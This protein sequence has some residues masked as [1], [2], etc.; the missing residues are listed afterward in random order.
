[1]NSRNLRAIYLII[2]IA[3]SVPSVYGKAK[4]SND[5]PATK[6]IN[7]KEKFT[8]LKVEGNIE[9]NYTQNS[10]APKAIVKAPVDLMD[11]I[12]Y[13][14]TPQGMLIFKMSKNTKNYDKIVIDL[15]GGLLNNYDVTATAQINILTPVMGK[16][17]FNFAASSS[18]MV[19]AQKEVGEGS[20]TINIAASS[21]SELVF[22]AKIS[23]NVV[24]LAI[25]SATM[26]KMASLNVS[27]LNY[28]G[29]SLG[30]LNVETMKADNVNV[31][32]SSGSECD[33]ATAKASNLRISASSGSEVTM[34]NCDINKVWLET[35]SGS[36]ATLSGKCNEAVLSSSSVAKINCKKL[37]IANIR[38]RNSSTGGSI[39]L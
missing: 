25:S 15:N 9:V 13:K 33:I 24:N 3:L 16:G 29:S 39:S 18:G 22:R 20:E 1:M 14:V 6:T 36:V 8:G 5:T 38:S 10:N 7:I 19:V 26:I 32:V 11:E 12:S 17:P 23:G 30:I 35:S 34:A 37:K 27:T 2:L 4:R 31:S 28:A 21:S